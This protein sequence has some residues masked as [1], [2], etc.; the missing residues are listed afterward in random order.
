MVHAWK[1]HPRP[2][3]SVPMGNSEHEWAQQTLNQVVDSVRAQHPDLGID[4]RLVSGSPVEA[5]LASTDDTE[6]LVLGSRGLGGLAGFLVGSVSQ[7]VVARSVRPVVL[8]RAGR[9]AADEYPTTP[10]R[11]SLRAGDP[12]D[13]VPRRRPRSGHPASL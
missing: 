13:A 8:V 2:P 12:R 11:A 7:R 4:A 3:A 5:L 9:A 1:W 10:G 6:L